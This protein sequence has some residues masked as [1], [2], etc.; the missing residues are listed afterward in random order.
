M[1]IH[2]THAAHQIFPT[3]QP[4]GRAFER[5]GGQV[6]LSRANEGAQAKYFDCCPCQDDWQSDNNDKKN[7]DPAFHDVAPFLGAIHQ[8]TQRHN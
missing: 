3:F 7:S 8:P 6:T 2:A 1:A 4:G 5:A